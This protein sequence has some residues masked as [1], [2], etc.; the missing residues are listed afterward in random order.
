MKLMIKFT[1]TLIFLSIFYQPPICGQAVSLPDNYPNYKIAA[2]NSPDP[3]YLFITSR[4]MKDKFPAYMMILDNYG[5][6]VYY[7]YM[8]E[9]AGGMQVQRNGLLSFK[10]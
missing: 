7:R 6:P 5:T 9:K 3:G 2:N 4:P 1:I 10:K 8:P